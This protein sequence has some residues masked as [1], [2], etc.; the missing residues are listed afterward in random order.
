MTTPYHP[1]VLKLLEEILLSV[2]TKLSAFHRVCTC[3]FFK[4]IDC[5]QQTWAAIHSSWTKLQHI[6]K[7][8]LWIVASVRRNIVKVLHFTTIP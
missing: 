6:Q 7:T 8:L 5:Y 3:D 4:E 1:H 2:L